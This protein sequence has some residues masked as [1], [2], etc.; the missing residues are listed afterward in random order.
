[1]S[2]AGLVPGT[3]G[4]QKH[5]R[6]GLNDVCNYHILTPPSFS[7][8]LKSFR[9]P[10]FETK[11]MY[12]L[13]LSLPPKCPTSERW[14][15]ESH[16]GDKLAIYTLVDLGDDGINDLI[17]LLQDGEGG[18][19]LLDDVPHLPHKY[20]FSGG[21]L[22]DVYDYHLTLEKEELL[23]FPTLFAVAHHQDYRK[24]GVLLV[25]LDADFECSVDF[26]RSKASGVVL[27][28][29]NIMI[30][31]IGWEEIKSFDPPL[32]LSDDGNDETEIGNDSS[33]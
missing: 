23:L 12:S 5:S 28:A 14:H 10:I 11:T 24:Y 29:V 7:Q 2:G 31:N 33:K 25:N 1:M 15:H 17:K 21:S 20:D 27:S 18:E 19:P 22:R 16:K 13:D 3:K 32:P 9:C 4:K 8:I 30:S 26:H 6:R